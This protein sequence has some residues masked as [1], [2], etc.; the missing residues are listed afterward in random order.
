[1]LLR[2][3][4]ERAD[5]PLEELQLQFGLDGELKRKKAITQ[6]EAVISKFNQVV[7]LDSLT[8]QI[9]PD[10]TTQTQKEE[11]KEPEQ[12]QAFSLGVAG[13]QKATE[14]RKTRQLQRMITLRKVVTDDS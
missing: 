13:R 11:T 4:R 14:Q 3:K 7:A 5:E 1:M 12:E 10:K 9:I 8:R 6:T 2:V